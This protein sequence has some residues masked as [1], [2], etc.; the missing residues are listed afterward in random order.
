[1]NTISLWLYT[2][3]N[4]RWHDLVCAVNTSQ[5]NNLRAQRCSVVAGGI[6]RTL[7]WVVKIPQPHFVTPH[8]RRIH[9]QSKNVIQHFKVHCKHL[10][11]MTRSLVC[12]HNFDIFIHSAS[13]FTCYTNVLCW[14]VKINLKDFCSCLLWILQ[15]IKAEPKLCLFNIIIMT[16]LILSVK[17]DSKHKQDVW[18]DFH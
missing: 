15:P 8:P 7:D 6:Y 18:A 2:F 1:M 3:H 13:C 11:F 17:R 10:L 14:I 5:V 12:I 4:C 16:V 9:P